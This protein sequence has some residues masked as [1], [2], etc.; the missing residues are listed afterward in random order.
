[1][2]KG[3]SRR[4]VILTYHRVV[5]DDPLKD[6]DEIDEQQFQMHVATLSRFFNVLK[7]SDAVSGLRNGGLPG[8]AVAITF[9]DGYKDNVTA[10]LPILEH[11]GVPAT[12]FI[13]TGFLD[14]GIMWNDMAIE[15]VRRFEGER[16][17]LDDLDLGSYPARE[18]AEKIAAYRQ[19]V[20]KLRYEPQER[21]NTLCKAIAERLEVQLPTDLMMSSGDLTTLRDAGMEIGAH[22]RNHPILAVVGE[23]DARREIVDGKRDVEQIL[24]AEVKAFAYP[25]GRPGQDY[26]ACH[27]DMVRDAG[28]ELA[29]ST[30]AGSV[31]TEADVFQLGRVSVWHRSK[32]KLILRMLKNYFLGEPARA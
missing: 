15:S 20:G 6:P 5:A 28:F 22:T 14:G 8:R 19:I 30:G 29:V 4:L 27:V 26:K 9:D 12:F 17:D 10:A 18:P 24:G 11:Y 25:N 21:R 2:N 31:S 16:I 13:A 23:D 7:L 32:P 3:N 1:V